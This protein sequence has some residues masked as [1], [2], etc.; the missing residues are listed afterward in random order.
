MNVPPWLAE[1]RVSLEQHSPDRLALALA[2]LAPAAAAPLPHAAA[3]PAPFG[4]SAASLLPLTHAQALAQTHSSHNSQTDPSLAP[5][6]GTLPLNSSPLS[7]VHWR[8]LAGRRVLELRRVF[9]ASTPASPA[10]HALTGQLLPLPDSARASRVVEIHLPEPCLPEPV[11]LDAA[12]SLHLMLVTLS[13]SFYRLVFP[14]PHLFYTDSLSVVAVSFRS[15][16]FSSADRVPVLAHFP[17]LDTVMIACGNG[18]LVQINCPLDPATSPDAIDPA[19]SASDNGALG[20]PDVAR[21]RRFASY[22]EHELVETSYMSQLSSLVRTPSKYLS[23]AFRSNFSADAAGDTASASGSGSGYGS[24]SQAT[25]PQQPISMAS[26]CFG[27]Q[28]F[29]FTFSRDSRLRI[30]NLIS[31]HTSQSDPYPSTPGFSRSGNASAS[32]RPA[33]LPPSPLSTLRIFDERA[34]EPEHL[35]FK[36][37]C[38]LPQTTTGGQAA[39]VLNDFDPISF[40]VDFSSTAMDQDA[41]AATAYEND[42]DDG[43]DDDDDE[44]SDDGDSASRRRSSVKRHGGDASW[45]TL[46]TLWDRSTSTI[47]RYTQLILP[48]DDANASGKQTQQPAPIMG[49]ATGK[50]WISPAELPGL[51]D[52]DDYSE[53]FLEHIFEPGRFSLSTIAAAIKCLE[54][55][56]PHVVPLYQCVVS[57][58]QDDQNQDTHFANYDAALL[59]AYRQFLGLLSA[60]AGIC[61]NPLTKTIL[62]VQ[63]GP[64]MGFLRILG[65]PD[66]APSL[67]FASDLLFNKALRT[68]L[69]NFL[70]LIGQVT[71]DVMGPALILTTRNSTD[72]AVEDYAASMDPGVLGDQLQLSNW[73]SLSNATV[74]TNDIIASVATQMVSALLALLYNVSSDLLRDYLDW[75]SRQQQAKPASSE[76]LY[77]R[78]SSLSLDTE[79]TPL[80]LH[81]LQ[82]HYIL[83]L[84]TLFP[85]LLTEAAGAFLVRLGLDLSAPTATWSRALVLLSKK[86]LAYGHVGLVDELCESMLRRTPAV[87]YIKGHASTT[88]L[89]LV[90]PPETLLAGSAEYYRHIMDLFFE[91]NVLDMTVRFARLAMGQIPQDKWT[92]R[93][94][95]VRSLN[96][97]IFSCCVDLADFDGAYDAILANPDP[98]SAARLSA[99]N[100]L[101][102]LC[103][104]FT[105]GSLSDEVERTLEFKA[106]TG[107]LSL[108]SNAPNYH[109]IC[110]TYYIYRGDYRSASLSMYAL[111]CK[112]ATQP[113]PPIQKRAE[114]AQ[115]PQSLLAALNG[116]SL[117]DAEHAWIAVPESIASALGQQQRGV[118]AVIPAAEDE[119]SAMYQAD[120]SDGDDLDSVPRAGAG[121]GHSVRIVEVDDIRKAYHLALAKLQL[122]ERFPDIVQSAALLEAGDALSMYCQAGLFDAALSFVAVLGL[123]PARVFT[124]A[125]DRL[126]LP[127]L[128]LAGLAA[129]ADAFGG[130]AAD[131]L[132]DDEAVAYL[133]AGGDNTVPSGSGGS[134]VPASASA[135]GKWIRLKPLLDRYDGRHTGFQHH[136]AVVDAILSQNRL[137]SLPRWLTLPFET[138]HSDELV[139]LYLRHDRILDA[140]KLADQYIRESTNALPVQIRASTG[141]RW[142]S[143][144]TIEHVLR[145]LDLAASQS[146]GVSGGVGR[147]PFDDWSHRLQRSFGVFGSQV[148]AESREILQ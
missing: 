101:H 100:D 44:D 63:R 10:S 35:L 15:S 110:Y 51:Y 81:L 135:S 104:K 57:T 59:G 117:L 129:K 42:G 29:L 147:K 58:D 105:F 2:P 69:F 128:S 115:I 86:L 48:T 106:R 72:T 70:S 38:F 134:G 28:F 124:A 139:R 114:R 23:A 142:V 96:K 46:W 20:S 36:I 143:V 93:L 6:A 4:A 148:Q 62:T 95:E 60:P 82:H 145:A 98:N 65:A 77:G 144:S 32:A 137:E 68:D 122:H 52:F 13:G 56:D 8:L 30:W 103:S 79:H 140:A 45:W 90:L 99:H 107:V 118:D 39:F 24:S 126:A 92:Q 33:L 73:P 121:S 127:S 133:T 34:V 9:V 55:K 119:D 80:F 125:V 21:S 83:D 43:D 19:V 71:A 25:S 74:F 22:R 130:S 54:G 91:H 146:I 47:I 102:L 66:G 132:D 67:L 111:A 84:D 78:M 113:L 26:L 123:D 136:L 16:L 11:L 3:S 1:S 53:L 7:L 112:L 49:L 108:M 17:D 5:L 37:M 61:Y 138:Y 76:P 64:S 31:R 50:R 85:M 14:A 131:D 120:D 94:A 27:D 40:L 109:R 89:G 116:L 18:S 87:E 141:G 88:D 12:G 41:N 97:I 75:L